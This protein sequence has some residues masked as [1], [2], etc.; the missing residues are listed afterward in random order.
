[1]SRRRFMAGWSKTLDC[2]LAAKGSSPGQGKTREFFIS[3]NSTL[4]QTQSSLSALT[5]CAH[6]ALGLC[7]TFSRARVS[8]HGCCRVWPWLSEFS[9]FVLSCFMLSHLTIFAEV[10]VK[11]EDCP[12]PLFETVHYSMSWVRRVVNIHI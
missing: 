8:M 5:S 1:M 12:K 9:D 2:C 6:H 7:S 11:A 10:P 4:V 3:S